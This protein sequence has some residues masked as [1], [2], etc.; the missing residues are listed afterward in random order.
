MVTRTPLTIMLLSS[1]DSVFPT[2]SNGLRQDVTLSSDGVIIVKL[3][4]FA[5]C[6][7]YLL[8]LFL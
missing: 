5:K 3:S 2:H 6:Y 7:V 4:W 8:A 1:S